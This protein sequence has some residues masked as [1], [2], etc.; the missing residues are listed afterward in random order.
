MSVDKP[1]YG[2]TNVELLDKSYFIH[3]GL[4]FS[5]PDA[6]IYEEVAIS[7]QSGHALPCGNIDLLAFS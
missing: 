1:D 7:G 3:L 2:C 4:A 6:I 5:L